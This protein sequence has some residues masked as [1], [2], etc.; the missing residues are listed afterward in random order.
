M[1]DL[2]SLSKGQS[3]ADGALVIR[4]LPQSYQWSLRMR[5]SN[6]HH[7]SQAWNS[8]LNLEPLTSSSAEE[9]NAFR[10]GPDEWLLLAPM[11]TAADGLKALMKTVALSLV[12]I[13]DREVAW[14]ISGDDAAHVLAA[15]C[16]LDLSDSSFPQGRATRTVYGHAEIILWR[17]LP[18]RTWHIRAS[19]S[20]ASYLTRHMA[21]A[22]SNLPSRE[23]SL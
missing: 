3:F 13:S 10:L 2:D 6:I 11:P 9:R 18:E 22:V 20:F 21:H 19:R 15:G 7:G 4:P 12:E 16:P 17:P 23:M 1:S 8:C 14:E 5:P